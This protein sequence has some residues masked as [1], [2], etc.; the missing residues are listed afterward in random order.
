MPGVPAFSLTRSLPSA[1]PVL[2]AVPHA[3][4]A[5]PAEALAKMRHPASTALKLEDRYADLLGERVARRTGAALLVAQAPRALIDLNRSLDDVDWDMVARSPCDAAATRPAPG[6]R[7]RSGLGL[8]PRR[9]AGLGDIWRGQLVEDELAERIGSI[10]EPYHTCLSTELDALRRRWGHALLLDLHSMPPLLGRGPA[11]RAEFVLG[12]R[13]GATCHG[14]IVAAAFG[15][16][17]AAGRVAAHNRPYAGGYGLDRH[18]SPAFGLHA[19]QLE[20]DRSRYLDAQL[21]EPGAGFDSIVDLLCELVNRLG[22]EVA[23]LGSRDSWAEAA[24]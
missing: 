2:I 23:D 6:L 22:I 13:F 24:E 7:A 19:M 15:F 16:F 5:Y 4:R 14:G 20:V 9:L 21:A 10:H 11:Q 8:I 12:D 3:G 1:L 18:A 17:S